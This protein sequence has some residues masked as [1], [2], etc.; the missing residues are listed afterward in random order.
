MTTPTST[1]YRDDPYPE[2]S[3]S[4]DVSGISHD[5]ASFAVQSPELELA[6]DG[7]HKKGRCYYSRLKKS[8]ALFFA[9][10]DGNL[11]W[12]ATVH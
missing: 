1:C 9:S 7:S 12:M 2:S 6:Y 4:D 3:Y 11:W 5:D 10:C 8:P